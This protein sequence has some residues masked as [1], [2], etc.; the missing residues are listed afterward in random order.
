M[1]TIL[2]MTT[3]IIPAVATKGRIIAMLLIGAAGIA[4]GVLLRRAD[5]SSSDMVEFTALFGLTIFVP[6]VALVIATASLGSLIEDKTLVYFWLRPLGRWQISVASLLAGFAVLVPLILIPM[7]VLGAVT[8]DNSALR[9]ILVGSLVGLVAYTSV[10]TM[11]G[12]FTQRA[13]AWGLLY[14]LVWEGLVAGF[15]RGAGWLAIRTYADGA[16]ARAG[17]TPGRIANP[18]ESSTII[19]VTVAVSVVC[20][21]ITTW[22][23]NNMTVD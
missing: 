8:G 15:S 18:P 19:I 21:A 5:A 11:L 23:L 9:G 14:V 10:F 4:I 17:D 3:R 6:L 16:L 1:N 20:F 2:A 13:L 12:L 22:R 7:G